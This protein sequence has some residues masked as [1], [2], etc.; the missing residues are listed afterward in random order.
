MALL[1]RLIFGPFH[2]A[3]NGPN[4]PTLTTIA[5]AGKLYRFQTGLSRSGF[6]HFK[7]PRR[8]KTLENQRFLPPYLSFKMLYVEGF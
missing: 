5:A 2:P 1:I 8:Q 7:M 3:Q 6:K 4:H